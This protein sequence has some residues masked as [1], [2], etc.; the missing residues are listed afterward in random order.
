MVNYYTRANQSLA[1]LRDSRMT[2]HQQIQDGVYCTEYDNSIKVYVNYTN[3]EITVHGVV[4]GAKDCVT[5]S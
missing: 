4:I 2:S 5:I 3:T 1:Y